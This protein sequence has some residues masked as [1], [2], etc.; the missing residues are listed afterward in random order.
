MTPLDIKKDH[1]HLWTETALHSLHLVH[2]WRGSNSIHNKYIVK[3]MPQSGE[4]SV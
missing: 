1:G 3:L 2:L 4:L